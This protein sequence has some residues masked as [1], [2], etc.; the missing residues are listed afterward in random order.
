MNIEK[1]YNELN[2]YIETGVYRV[3]FNDDSSVV[4]NVLNQYYVIFNLDMLKNGYAQ[5]TG[6]MINSEGLK[7]AS[8][9]KNFMY[10][11]FNNLSEQERRNVLIEL[12]DE[13]LQ[14]LVNAKPRYDMMEPS[15]NVNLE[16][17]ERLK[18]KSR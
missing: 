9:D 7:S 15:E 5:N 1:F 6:L 13:Y 14:R 12:R 18:Q 3:V 4:C 2:K 8:R 17:E 10:H 16:L 11:Y